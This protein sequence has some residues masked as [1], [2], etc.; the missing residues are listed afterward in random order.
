MVR[1]AGKNK[2]GFSLVEVMVAMVILTVSGLALSH[3]LVKMT[4]EGKVARQKTFA[5]QKAIQMMNELRAIVDVPDRQSLLNLDRYNDG[6]DFSYILTT[7]RDVS[8]PGHPMSGNGKKEFQRQIHISSVT[9]NRLARRVTVKVYRSEDMQSLA[10]TMAVIRTLKNEMPSIQ[11]FDIHVLDIENV[12]RWSKNVMFTADTLKDA[13]KELE[14]KNPGLKINFHWIG[15]LGSGRDIFYR[16]SFNKGEPT[17]KFDLAKY[18]TSVYVYPGKVKV[19]DAGGNQFDYYESAFNNAMYLRDGKRSSN[20][21]KWPLAD[22]F[23]HAVRLPEYDVSRS[24]ISKEYNL[25]MFLEQLNNPD[26]PSNEDLTNALIINLHNG[27]LPF[28]PIRNYADA[29]KDPENFP[30]MRVVTHP[31]NIMY[32]TGKKVFMRVYSYVTNPDHPDWNKDSSVDIEIYVKGDLTNISKYK[33]R[34][35]D[36]NKDT[37]YE[38]KK[39]DGPDPSE[40]YDVVYDT[41]TERTTFTLYDSPLLHTLNDDG[42]GGLA[43]DQRLYDM[44]YIPSLIQEGDKFEKDE[45]DLADDDDGNGRRKNTARWRIMMDLGDGDAIPIVTSIKDMKDHN[46]SRTWAWVGEAPPVTEQYQFLGDPRHMPYADV[47]NNKGYNWYFTGIDPTDDYKVPYS[48]NGWD[49]RDRDDFHEDNMERHVLEVDVPKIYAM[50]REGIMNSNAIMDLHDDFSWFLS[51]GGEIGSRALSGSQDGIPMIEG[52]WKPGSDKVINVDETNYYFNKDVPQPVGSPLIVRGSTW[53]WFSKA[54]LGELYPDDM[55]TLTWRDLGNLPTGI[56]PNNGLH[57]FYR[58]SYAKF[59]KQSD[60]KK[61]SEPDPVYPGNKYFTNNPQRMVYGRAAQSLFNGNYNAGTDI[62]QGGFNIYTLKNNNDPY[63]TASSGTEL[64]DSFNVPLRSPEDGR[65]GFVMDDYDELP[66]YEWFEEPYKNIMRTFTRVISVFYDT[67]FYRKP[68]TMSG[69][70]DF[71]VNGI[72]RLDRLDPSAYLKNHVGYFSL[73]MMTSKLK[74]RENRLGYEAARLTLLG[75]IQGFM[76]AGAP[77]NVEAKP[78]DPKNPNRYGRIPQLPRIVIEEPYHKDIFTIP[79]PK[80]SDWTIEIKW[81][82]SWRRWDGK[83]YTKSYSSSF[84]EDIKL[85]YYVHY[86][87]NGKRWEFLKKIYN[88]LNEWDLFEYNHSYTWHINSRDRGTYEL[89][90]IAERAG[91]DLHKSY[92]QIQVTI[93]R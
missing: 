19:K 47:K 55:Y 91:H 39:A 85:I 56:D 90:V 64:V 82:T 52:F 69:P 74:D 88:P 43:P 70:F 32:D 61:P 81:S 63:L 23:N 79:D 12:S 75:L 84:A 13:A 67:D 9:N 77:G 18:S 31:E 45:Y 16:P 7:N 11:K 36:G 73:N 54:W 25:H 10:E 34:K 44:E 15:R 60:R 8:D 71:Y 72:M 66:R 50:Y 6:S 49:G 87:R 21:K 40:E 86:R 28:P 92:H 3:L 17:D 29:A 41:T 2:L 57:K 59:K 38:W 27:V 89:R 4:H 5:T 46:I 20:R 83:P 53:S 62:H 93:D 80:P 33:I 37:E 51:L 68:G 30:Y 78:D 14:R 65:L 48:Y 35:M 58:A 26:P 42:D 76:D 24:S 1:I 22:Q